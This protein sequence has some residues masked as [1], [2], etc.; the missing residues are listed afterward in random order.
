MTRCAAD[1][2]AMLGAIAG[3]DIHD[4]T[5]Y[6]A[7]VPDYL[8]TLGDGVRGLRIGV[9]R[10]YATDGVD[11]QV[12]AALGEAER[13]FVGLRATIREVR[14]PSYQKLVS[15][16]ITMCSVETAA[17]HAETYPR[18]RPEYGPDLAALIDQGLAAKGTEI[19]AI[20]LERLGFARELVGPVRESRRAARFRPCRCRLRASS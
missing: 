15:Q 13:V 3:P 5:T 1:A 14:F 12:A 4:P 2:A 17:A 16:W 11:A 8:E 18:R 6:S 9:D 19:A 20:N 7:A 10:G